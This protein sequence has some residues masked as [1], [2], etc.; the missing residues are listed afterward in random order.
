MK[1]LF[2][3]F[4]G[5]LRNSRNDDLLLNPK[6]YEFVKRW[7]EQGNKLVIATARPFKQMKSYLVEKYNLK[8]DYLICSNGGAVF[9]F[10]GE[11]LFSNPITNSD[12]NALLDV[13]E[14]N[15]EKAYGVIYSSINKEDV[16]FHKYWND[17]LTEA[18]LGLVPENLPVDAIRNEGIFSFRLVVDESLRETFKE[19]DRNYL[20]S[21]FFYTNYGDELNVDVTNS[22][23]NKGYAIRGLQ[24]VLG[25][26]DEDVYVV[27][28]D[29]NDKS[30]FKE[31]FE[32]SFIVRQDRNETFRHKAK[33]LIEQIYE[34][35]SLV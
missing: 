29:I 5:T 21:A 9:N 26:K 14:T 16:L 20:D 3:D 1:W 35:E 27:G 31:F 19:F 22:L 7:Q 30:M 11:L 15:E 34:I 6:D 32:T 24:N 8:P 25:F 28:D 23:T 2:T 4:D 18:Y 10:D 13:I 33:N 17:M 12:L